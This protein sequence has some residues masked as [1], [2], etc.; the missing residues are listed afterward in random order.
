M[1]DGIDNDAET[2]AEQRLLAYFVTLR[3]APPESTERLVAKVVHAAR[4]QSAFRPYLQVV[5]TLATG[6]VVAARVVAD[7]HTKR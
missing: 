7:P 1:T 2:P 3:D 5:G 4:W 6:L